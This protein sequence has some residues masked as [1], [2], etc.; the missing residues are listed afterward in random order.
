MLATH[1]VH[2]AVLADKLLV[3]KDVS[4]SSV[5]IHTLMV[6]FCVSQGVVEAYNSYSSLV[7]S[8]YNTTRLLGLISSA[9]EEKVDN[10]SSGKWCD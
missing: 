2:F 8:G 3:L 1:Q 9:T 5:L 4:F 10:E 6:A 7:A